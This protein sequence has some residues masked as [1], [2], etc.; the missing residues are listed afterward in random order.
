MLRQDNAIKKGVH[1]KLGMHL[2][3]ACAASVIGPRADE[4]HVNKLETK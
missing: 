4:S 3:H 1:T 2:I